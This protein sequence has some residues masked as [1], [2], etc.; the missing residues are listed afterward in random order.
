[1]RER[2]RAVRKHI[3]VDCRTLDPSVVPCAGGERW[4]GTT[5]DFGPWC[6]AMRRGRKGEAKD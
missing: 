3:T 4:D 6:G 5:E 1:M 2:R